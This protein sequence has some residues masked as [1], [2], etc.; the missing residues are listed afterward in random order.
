MVKDRIFN[1]AQIGVVL[2]CTIGVL[3]I[4]KTYQNART[5]TGKVVSEKFVRGHPGGFF[6]SNESHKYCINI[7]PL[8]E[9]YDKLFSFRYKGIEAVEIDSKYDV[10]SIVK[11]KEKF[12]PR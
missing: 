1:Y 11:W 2:L 12:K 9:K 4:N 5:L 10:G 7:R 6:N 8:D 3:A